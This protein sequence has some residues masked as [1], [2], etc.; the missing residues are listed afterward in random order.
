MFRRFFKSRGFRR[1]VLAFLWILLAFFVLNAISA[2]FRLRSLGIP[3][4]EGFSMLRGL[5]A[6]WSRSPWL[7]GLGV[8]AG[9]AWYFSRRSADRQAGEAEAEEKPAEEPV[10]PREE[11]VTEETMTETKTHSA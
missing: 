5:F 8:I 6:D 3:L 9:V 7:I 10:P 2:L 11:T 1:G 4:R